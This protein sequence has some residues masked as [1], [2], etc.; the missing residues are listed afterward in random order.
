MA[1]KSTKVGIA[2]PGDLE[3]TPIDALSEVAGSVFGAAWNGVAYRWLAACDAHAIWSKSVATSNAPGSDERY[4]QEAALFHFFADANS[5]LEAFYLGCYGIA[6]R[7]RPGDFKVDAGA[8]RLYPPDVACK[9][10]AVWPDEEA[11]AALKALVKST[12]Y[13][14]L[15]DMRDALA[16]RGPLPR[17]FHKGGENDG[18]AF[19]PDQPK[20]SPLDW[21]FSL[22]VEPTLTGRYLA[23]LAKSIN[24]AA[25]GLLSWATRELAKAPG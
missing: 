20:A 22:S 18:Q 24:H 3:A 16:H 5:C 6:V 2:L 14:E 17:R 1:G 7:L 13:K 21:E 15:K 8:L 12:E 9:M 4:E 23:W 11:V 25:S 10:F 19:L